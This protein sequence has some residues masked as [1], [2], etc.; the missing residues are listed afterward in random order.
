MNF[1]G[2]AFQQKMAK[3]SLVWWQNYA[4]QRYEAKKLC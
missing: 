1:L 3:K 4:L 2:Q